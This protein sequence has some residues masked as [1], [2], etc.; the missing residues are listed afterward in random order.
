MIITMAI[1]YLFIGSALSGFMVRLG[2]LDYALS[3]L[4]VLFWPL[5]LTAM[6]GEWIAW[7][8]S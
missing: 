6:I 2:K 7:K 8:L 1:L 4:V 3:P 5:V